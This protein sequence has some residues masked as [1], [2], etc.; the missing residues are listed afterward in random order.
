MKRILATLGV[1]GL[2]LLGATAPATAGGDDGED[3]HMVT[4][5]H[6][7]GSESNPY[8]EITVDWHA[9][10]AHHSQHGDD[11][12]PGNEKWGGLNWDGDGRAIYYN[13]CEPCPE[14]PVDH[15]EEPPVVTPEEPPV[16]TPEEPV[17]VVPPVVTP[18]APPVVPPVVAPIGAVVAPPA[19]PAVVV[20][21]P[22]LN[23][24]TAV[25]PT[26]SV[27]A[28]WA[29]GLIVMLLAA[30]GVAARKVLMAGGLPGDRKD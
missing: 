11:I 18:E 24:Q 27:L 20:R 2:A 3:D 5:C 6:A 14:P 28:P 25:A 7:T 4:I 21:N 22:G 8:E 29:A 13:G 10:K 15:P 30:A 9:V 26:G 17:V 23:V 19:A 12:I 16:V 1:T